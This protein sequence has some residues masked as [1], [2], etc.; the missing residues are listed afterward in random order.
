LDIHIT[1]FD[2]FAEWVMNK[3]IP[4]AEFDCSPDELSVEELLAPPLPDNTGDTIPDLL[5]AI[6]EGGVFLKELL[7]RRASAEKVLK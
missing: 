4:G 7:A 2:I 6:E 1:G 3:V 5:E